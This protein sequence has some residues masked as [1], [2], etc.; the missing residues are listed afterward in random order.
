MY[1]SA[2]F[3]LFGLL[4]E[5]S[6]RVLPEKTVLVSYQRSGRPCEAAGGLVAANLRPPVLQEHGCGVP[7][8]VA[9][10]GAPRQ[11]RPLEGP[12]CDRAP[13]RLDS[14]CRGRGTPPDEAWAAWQAAQRHAGCAGAGAPASSVMPRTHGGPYPVPAGSLLVPRPRD[15][16]LP[17]IRACVRA[18]SHP[19]PDQPDRL[20]RGDPCPAP[21]PGSRDR[22]TRAPIPVLAGQGPRVLLYN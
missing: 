19:G 12:E 20:T 21:V 8:A 5:G 22:G 13:L 18:R 7:R 16:K 10:G 3:V 11:C 9:R 14:G 4:R 2:G 6:E 17:S 1:F 15:Q